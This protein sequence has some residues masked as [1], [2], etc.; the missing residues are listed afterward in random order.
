[1][2]IVTNRLLKKKCY[3]WKKPEITIA[4]LEELLRRNVLVKAIQAGIEERKK[5]NQ[6]LLIITLK[7]LTKFVYH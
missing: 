1:M 6:N 2:V 7:F 5:H 3:K 4:V